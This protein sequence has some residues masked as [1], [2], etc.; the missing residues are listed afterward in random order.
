MNMIWPT[1]GRIVR[2]LIAGEWWPAIAVREHWNSNGDHVLDA[3]AFRPYPHADSF[4][5]KDDR[6]FDTKAPD[7]C[8]DWPEAQKP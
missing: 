8:W 3:C 7:Y 2:V 1:P 6:K 4:L 5:A